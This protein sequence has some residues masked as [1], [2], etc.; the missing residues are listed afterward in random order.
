MYNFSKGGWV[1]HVLRIVLLLVMALALAG[2]SRPASERL[3]R[4]TGPEV[5]TLSAFDETMKEFMVAR[6][7]SAGALAIT[8]R[9]RLVVARGYSWAKPDSPASATGSRA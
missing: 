6:E 1:V 7:I 9:G 5:P 8:Y 4:Q 3:W 2:C